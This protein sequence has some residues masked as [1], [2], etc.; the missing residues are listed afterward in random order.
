MGDQSQ[1]LRSRILFESALHDYQT[2]TGTALASHPLAEKLQNCDSVQAVTAV[3]QEQ[4]RAFSDIRGGDGKI[5]ELLGHIVSALHTLSASA[6]LGGVTGLVR[7]NTSIGVP[8][9]YALF[10]SHYHLQRPYFL[11]SPSC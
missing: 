3:L 5:M 7:R 2:Q 1:S 9:T 6:I 8:H 10:Y 11:P 4:A